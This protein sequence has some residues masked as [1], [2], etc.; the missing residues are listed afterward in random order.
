MNLKTF[1]I[2][3]CIFSACAKK[4]PH[5]KSSSDSTKSFVEIARQEFNLSPLGQGGSFSNNGVD[6]LYADF[7]FDG[8]VSEEEAKIL[9]FSVTDRFLNYANSDRSLKPF[10]NIYPL[11]MSQMS[12]SIAFLDKNKNPRS[13]LAQIHLFDGKIFYSHYDKEK[14]AYIAYRNEAFPLAYSLRVE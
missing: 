7:S 4:P 10:L 6:A 5:V 3:G 2:V 8:D 14:K 9:L 13:T 11:S 1:L 12:V